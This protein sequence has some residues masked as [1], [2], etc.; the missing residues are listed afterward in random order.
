MS[1]NNSILAQLETKRI[2]IETN[3]EIISKAIKEKFG[4]ELPLPKG[5]PKGYKVDTMVDII[6][7]LFDALAVAVEEHIYAE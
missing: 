4:I 3:K 1:E 7:T 5:L 2:R 6:N